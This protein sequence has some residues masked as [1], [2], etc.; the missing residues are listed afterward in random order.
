MDIPSWGSVLGGSWPNGVSEIWASSNMQ[1]L[2]LLELHTIHFCHAV[3]DGVETIEDYTECAMVRRSRIGTHHLYSYSIHQSQSHGL[4]RCKGS[5]GMQC[6]CVSR[7]TA[8]SL[9]QEREQCLT[10][11]ENVLFLFLWPWEGHSFSFSSSCK[12]RD[13]HLLFKLCPLE[14]WTSKQ[15]P[16]KEWCDGASWYWLL[17]WIAKFYEILLAC[18]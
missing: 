15:V 17:T 18:C 12:T 5:C 2:H 16:Y 6:S 7:R 11:G 13:M 8:D 14:P 3:G 1:L 4:R 10:L 9:P